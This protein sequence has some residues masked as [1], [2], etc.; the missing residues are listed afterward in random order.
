[1]NEKI[2]KKYFFIGMISL[3]LIT[4]YVMAMPNLSNIL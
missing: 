3:L 2:K 4:G 1:M